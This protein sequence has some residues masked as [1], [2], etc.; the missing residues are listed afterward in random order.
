MVL[1]CIEVVESIFFDSNDP[2]FLF[3]C[4]QGLYSS[5]QTHCERVELIS[6]GRILVICFP[7]LYAAIESLTMTHNDCL[8]EPFL[9]HL[10]TPPLLTD[11]GL[12]FNFLE[13]WRARNSIL[14][15]PASFQRPLRGLS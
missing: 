8:S 10:P 14:N 9:F 2:H 1:C 15:V 11:E 3:F 5:A 13:A 6:L 4:A 12:L 7:C